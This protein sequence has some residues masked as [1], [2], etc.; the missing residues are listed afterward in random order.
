M[1]IRAP[2]PGLAVAALATLGLG[3]CGGALP[4]GARSP[5]RLAA[6]IFAS[7]GRG[8]CPSPVWR[9]GTIVFAASGRVELVDLASCRVRVLAH[10]NAAVVRFS[11]DGRW[12]AYSRVAK[13]G[14]K[15]P[16]LVSVH[17]GRLRSPLGGGV[18]AW[19]WAPEGELLYAITRGGALVA[20]IST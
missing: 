13:G 2:W 15:G 14:L 8:V 12:V 10:A 5:P 18:L 19:Q 17:G 3:S 9:L 4:T 20:A 1:R 16:V 11:P 7:T 6:T